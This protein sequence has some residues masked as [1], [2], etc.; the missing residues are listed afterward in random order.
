MKFCPHCSAAVYEDTATHCP[1]CG[2]ELEV[3]SCPQCGRPLGV[4]QVCPHCA[5]VSSRKAEAPDAAAPLSMW[6]YLG[7]ILLNGIPLVG[8]I[9]M[10][11]WACGAGRNIHLTR[12][13]RGALLAHAVAFIIFVLLIFWFLSQAEPY[14]YQFMPYGFFNYMW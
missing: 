5:D 8:L 4:G 10:I 9:C 1:R 6:A 2:A 7:L 13:A 11:V 12:F 3:D 14:L